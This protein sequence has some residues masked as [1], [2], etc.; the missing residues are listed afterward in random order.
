VTKQLQSPQHH[1]QTLFTPLPQGTTIVV[2]ISPRC[3]QRHEVATPRN[4]WVCD[5]VITNFY[6]LNKKFQHKTEATQ[7]EVCALVN[8]TPFNYVA[9]FYGFTEKS[10]H[11]PSAAQ[12]SLVYKVPLC[13]PPKLRS[14]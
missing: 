13:F 10:F 11:Y 6:N 9:T 2:V 14:V 12:P 4:L 5:Q 8:D 3:L 7:T 1:F